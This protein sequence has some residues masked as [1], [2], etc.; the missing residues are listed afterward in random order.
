MMIT[1]LVNVAVRAI[2]RNKMRSS[3]TML[4]II[5]GVATVVAMVGIGE[6]ASSTVQNQIAAMGDNVLMVMSG[7]WNRG[8]VRGGTGSRHTLTLEDVDAIRARAPSVALVAAMTRSSA[9]VVAG[10]LNWPTG[11]IGT[12]PDYFTIRDMRVTQGRLFTTAENNSASKVCVIGTTVAENLFPG[13]DPV[14]AIIRVK[15][16][17]FTVIGVLESKGSSPFG[18]DQDDTL[19]APLLTVQR[20]ITG[21]T[22]I[23]MIFCSAL[24]RQ[25]TPQASEQITTILRS[26]HRLEKSEDDDFFVRTQTD[27]ASTAE[28]VT[29]V[30]TMML[31][32]IAAVSLLVGGIGIM[33]IM[34]VSVTERTRE[35]GIR[36]AVG[37]RPRDILWQ[38]LVEAI[39]LS[40]I[41]G[42]IGVALG[43]GICEAVSKIAG[44][45]TLVT[46]QTIILA[47]G[48]ASLVGVFFGF[49][50]ARKAARLDPIVALHYE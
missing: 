19:I 39:V 21:S 40:L 14:G 48:F 24:S 4:G 42:V 50:P 12:T 16:L 7:G 44:W 1:R 33:N 3:L 25:D 45:S 36:M 26:M 10:N 34:L 29:G 17:P 9:Q 18:G 37:A 35:I 43:Y 28:S 22:T 27:I 46:T 30:M 15:N 23:H 6:G 11:I 31:G 5:I 2:R 20:R 49:Y 47:M 8:G 32:S 41:G 38:F 13:S